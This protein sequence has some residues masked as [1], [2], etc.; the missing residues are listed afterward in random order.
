MNDLLVRE[1]LAQ[2][3]TTR[4]LHLWNDEGIEFRE[5]CFAGAAAKCLERHEEVNSP[6][7][8][9]FPRIAQFAADL[10]DDLFND[11]EPATHPREHAPRT[12][13]YLME[14]LKDLHRSLLKQ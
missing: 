6:A 4:H 1:E 10:D 3:F 8:G 2:A 11:L 12:S 5:E 14:L 9:E 13:N 7:I